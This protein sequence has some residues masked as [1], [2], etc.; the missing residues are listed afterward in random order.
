MGF[1][2]RGNN[3]SKV[4][5]VSKFVVFGVEVVRILSWKQ[6]G[7]KARS[8]DCSTTVDSSVYGWRQNSKD[9]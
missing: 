5:K 9:K 6:V 8:V 4:K 3:I 2:G 7:E 1:P